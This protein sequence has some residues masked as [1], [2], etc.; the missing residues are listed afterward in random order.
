MLLRIISLLLHPSR[1]FVRLRIR[2][3]QFSSALSGA[4]FFIFAVAYAVPNEFV[5]APA[6]PTTPGQAPKVNV[7][8]FIEQLTVL[9]L[10]TVFFAICWGLL[11]VAAA[12]EKFGPRA[13]LIAGSTMSMY[14]VASLIS[15][16]A[17][18]GTYIVTTTFAFAFASAQFTLMASYIHRHER[19]AKEL[20]RSETDRKEYVQSKRGLWNRE[21]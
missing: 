13:H 9:P 17:N 8:A 2:E 16:V 11:I 18:P 12:R 6:V 10:W 3:L 19:I 21:R 15:A 5:R 7:V 1:L 14:A 20:S 4:F